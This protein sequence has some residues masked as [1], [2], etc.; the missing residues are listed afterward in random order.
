MSIITRQKAKTMPET[1]IKEVED[2]SGLT[3]DKKINKLLNNTKDMLAMKKDI[4]KLSTSVKDL[5]ADV[6]ELK[7]NTD[8]I[9][10]INTQL[11]KLQTSLNALKNESTKDNKLIGDIERRVAKMEEENTDL[12]REIDSLKTKAKKR[13]QLG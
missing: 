6:T 10:D 4:K 1:P 9:P 3:I 13:D 5:T 2:D 8:T 12:K 11:K 7:Q